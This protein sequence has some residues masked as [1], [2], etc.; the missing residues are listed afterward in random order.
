MI[1]HVTFEDGSTL[2]PFTLT[3]GMHPELTHC[4]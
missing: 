1:L 3:E 4:A 2:G